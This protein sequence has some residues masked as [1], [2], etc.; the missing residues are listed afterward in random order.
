MSR[1]YLTNKQS[2]FLAYYLIGLNGTEAVMHAYNVKKRST[3]AVMA[4]ETLRIP[5]VAELVK[6][7]RSKV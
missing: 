6:A 2:A 1:K 4:S 7:Y 3:A 5:N